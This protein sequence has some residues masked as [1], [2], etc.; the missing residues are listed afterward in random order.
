MKIPIRN[1]KF[2]LVLALD[3]VLVT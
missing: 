3:I 1:W 2:W